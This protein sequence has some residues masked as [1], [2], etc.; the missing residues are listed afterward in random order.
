MNERAL[1]SWLAE[2][3]SGLIAAVAEGVR[4]HCDSL[5]FQGIDFYGYSLLPGEPDDLHHLV[6]AFN[7][8]T[9]IQ[10]PET[11]PMYRYYRYS[12]DA[13]EHYEQDLFRE[14]D[15]LVAEANQQFGALHSK[16]DDELWMDEFEI[17]HSN[18]LL[19]AVLQGLESAK[20]AG[21]FGKKDPYL[22]VWIA[23]SDHSILSESAQRLN[24]PAVA[25]EFMREFG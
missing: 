19:E 14:A 3:L 6:A 17:A 4:A 11:D 20:E 15:K 2:P 10:V 21:A 22:V 8:E 23:D 25:R 7:T 13:W 18:R 16:P 24:T 1:R 12:V 9:D 5:R